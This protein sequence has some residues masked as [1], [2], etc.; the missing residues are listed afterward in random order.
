MRRNWFPQMEEPLQLW[1]V[2]DLKA[3]RCMYSLI[4][5]SKTILVV[6]GQRWEGDSGSAVAD[7]TPR[8]A[9]TGQPLWLL[10]LV[11]GV[12]EAKAQGEEALYGETTRRFT[13]YASLE[14]AVRAAPYPMPGANASDLV[15][16][17]NRLALQLW[18]DSDGCIR[19]IYI[20]YSF[21]PMTLDLL[22]FGTPPPD[23]SRL[24]TF[25]RGLRLTS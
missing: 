6:R 17:H 14:R 10:D 3:H 2:L 9:G 4:G 20:R 25:T 13:A 11:R 15:V 1:G 21:A 5:T 18:V 7:L 12:T 23:W 8:P 22:A 19:R 16:D 24:Q